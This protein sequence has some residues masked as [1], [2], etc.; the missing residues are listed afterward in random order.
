MSERDTAPPSLGHDWGR[1]WGHTHGASAK[2]W[3]GGESRVLL[4]GKFSVP[5]GDRAVPRFNYGSDGLEI[6]RCQAS[7]HSSTCIYSLKDGLEKE[8]V[9]KKWGGGKF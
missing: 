7:T 4:G 8:R 6:S 3:V 2:W 5:A 1:Q 9:N